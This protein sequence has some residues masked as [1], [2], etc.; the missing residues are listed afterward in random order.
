MLGIGRLAPFR[1]SIF[2]CHASEDKTVAEDLALRLRRRQFNVFLDRHALSPGQSYDDRIE[3]EIIAR[4]DAFIF[5]VSPDSIRDGKYTLS[6]IDI[7]QKRWPDPHGHVLPVIVRTTPYEQIP[8]YLRAVTTLEPAGNIVAETAS[9]VEKLTVGSLRRAPVVA[10]IALVIVVAAAVAWVTQRKATERLT[11]GPPKEV[12]GGSAPGGSTT[13]PPVVKVADFPPKFHLIFTLDATDPSP[14]LDEKVARLFVPANRIARNIIR[15]ADDFYHE[16]LDTPLANA[17]L[18]ATVVREIKT[19]YIGEALKTPFCLRR[20]D[21]ATV[22][23]SRDRVILRCKEGDECNEPYPADPRL[24]LPVP[25]DPRRRTERN[26]ISLRPLAWPVTQLIAAAR[27][28]MASRVWSVPSIDSLLERRST[29]ELRDGFTVFTLRAATGFAVEADGVSVELAVNDTP[30]LVGG[31]PANL[32][33]SPFERSRPFEHRFALQNLNFNGRFSGCDQIDVKLAF[34]SQGEPAGPVVPLK[35]RYA[36]LRDVEPT[37]IATEH[38]TIVWSAR[39]EVANAPNAAGTDWRVFV[40]SAPQR[41][42]A[43]LQQAQ[44]EIDRLGLVYREGDHAS[45]VVAVLRPPLRN[46]AGLALGLLQATGQIR[47]TFTRDE[48]ERLKV[49]AVRQAAESAQLRRLLRGE[50]DLY[51]EPSNVDRRYSCPSPISHH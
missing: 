33:I 7:A 6:E 13:E 1:K 36:A 35:L 43:R 38:G 4:C 31:V 50:P 15:Q 23:A 21:P 10:L 2:V 51:Q 30:V 12:G 26:G 45:N 44:G 41:E 32:Q 14:Y 17:V 49:F 40:Q 42:I 9:A 18:S 22:D 27:A 25:C 29:R 16:I 8:S 39:Y 19:A 20:G 3:R 47:F 24:L 48:A 11:S 34:Y 28:E 37:R 46:E 5:L